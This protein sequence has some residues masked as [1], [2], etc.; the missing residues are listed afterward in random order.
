MLPPIP[1]GLIP[2]TVQQDPARPRPE[3][4][5]VT[6]ASESEA[7]SQVSLDHQQSGGQQQ[8]RRQSDT[9]GDS[10]EQLPEEE[11]LKP[12]K[13]A[14]ARKGQLINLRV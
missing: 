8:K 11:L 9:D 13:K 14:M 1:Q 7:N 2:V 10:E 4:Q 3:I 5:P 6:P 12:G